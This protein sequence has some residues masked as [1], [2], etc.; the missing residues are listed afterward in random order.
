MSAKSY[1]SSNTWV[2]YVLGLLAALGLFLYLKK[3]KAQQVE[4]EQV[5]EEEPGLNP[6]EV[7]DKVVVDN[8]SLIAETLKE[9]G[10]DSEPYQMLVTAQAMHETGYFT[11]NVMKSN[12]NYFGMRQPQVRETV[13]KGVKGGYA[14]YA[15]LKDSVTDYV[16]WNRYVKLPETYEKS[17]LTNVKAFV[18]ALKEK[19]YFEAS[20]LEYQNGVYKALSILKSLISAG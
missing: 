1:R 20:Y 5:E 12:N 13:S 17:D 15:N 18:K 19:G 14:S 3:K 4:Q 6:D 11:S 2:W 10:I 16:L 8:Y 7:A 9:N